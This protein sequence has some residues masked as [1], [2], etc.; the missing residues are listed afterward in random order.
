M[1]PPKRPRRTKADERE[2]INVLSFR[3]EWA[4]EDKESSSLVIETLVDGEP[5]AN[6][7]TVATDLYQLALSTKGDGDYQILNCWCGIPEC[8]GLFE[9]IQ[10]QHMDNAV[11]WRVEMTSMARGRHEPVQ[12]FVFKKDQYVE[13]IE[14]FARD[15]SVNESGKRIVLYSSHRHI[16]AGG[17]ERVLWE[18]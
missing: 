16:Q 18:K 2:A 6:F 11:R 4:G 10:V 13:S 1:K 8:A 12:Q 7:N 5:I 9:G 17:L 3:L 15:L 14:R